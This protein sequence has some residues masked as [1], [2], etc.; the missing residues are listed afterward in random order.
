MY[1]NEV[2]EESETL[3]DDDADTCVNLTGSDGCTM[4][5]VWNLFIMYRYKEQGT[6]YFDVLFTMARVQ[7]I[8]KYF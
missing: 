4:D 7:N 3:I 2:E 1:I 6:E 8:F 5:R